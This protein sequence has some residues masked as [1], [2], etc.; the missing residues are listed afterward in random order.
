MTTH[1]EIDLVQRRVLALYDETRAY[2]ECKPTLFLEELKQRAEENQ[3][4]AQFTLRT[5]AIINAAAC[6]MILES[7]QVKPE[8]AATRIAPITANANRRAEA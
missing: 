1:A 3:D 2:L 4:H 7:R 6:T 8:K 5:A